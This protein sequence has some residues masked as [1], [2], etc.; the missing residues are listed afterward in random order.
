[1]SRWDIFRWRTLAGGPPCRQGRQRFPHQAFLS[2][3]PKRVPPFGISDG[4]GT[5]MRA[6]LPSPSCQDM[7]P[8]PAH[9]VRRN[10]GKD[11][12]LLNTNEI[13]ETINMIDNEDLD[14]RTIT[15]GI[16]LLDCIDPDVHKASQKVYD[17]ICR[18][19]QHLVKTG[20]DI[21]RQ[22]G[23]PIINK[24]ISVTPI[25]MIAG[26]C[27]TASPIHFAKALDRAARTVGVNFIGGYSALVHKGFG[28]G[29][30]A[31]IESIPQALDE[32]EMVCSSVNVGTT[33]AG[34]N[35]DAVEKMGRIVK[36]TAQR[37]ADRECIGAA[38]LVVF[39][40]APEDNPFMAGAFHDDG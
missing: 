29:D 38:K 22:Y 3:R 1:M 2:P 6:A 18:Y 9:L 25:A 36:E 28:P 31:L 10:E 37:T 17:K 14:V 12:S 30:Y 16:S 15:M 5:R 21:S 26:A 35:M 34:I 33:K 13:L 11:D 39:C 4:G 7:T 23:I 8:P 19:A 24:R 32:T 27:P 40:N 20:E